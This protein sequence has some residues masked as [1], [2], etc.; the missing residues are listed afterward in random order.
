MRLRKIFSELWGVT[1]SCWHILMLF[2]L[3][4]G[5]GVKVYS[6]HT[7]RQEFTKYLEA[8]GILAVFEYLI[9]EHGFL[10][11]FILVWAAVLRHIYAK[12]LARMNGNKGRKRR[13]GSRS[14]HRR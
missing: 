12:E 1:K 14:P 3:W 8:N 2:S 5:V 7:D 13:K 4:F 6:N 11:G 10:V 9:L